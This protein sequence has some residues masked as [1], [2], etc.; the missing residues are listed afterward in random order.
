MEAVSTNGGDRIV[1]PLKW[2]GGKPCKVYD[3]VPRVGDIR[4]DAAISDVFASLASSVFE[5]R[6]S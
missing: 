6:H 1:P 4:S 5:F 2:H 3:L